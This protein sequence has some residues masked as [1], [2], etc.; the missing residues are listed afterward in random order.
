M[1]RLRKALRAASPA[2]IIRTIRSAGYS[3]E[4]PDG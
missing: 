4:S 2:T 3:L 1:S